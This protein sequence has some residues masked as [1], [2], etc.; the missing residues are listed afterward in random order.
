MK[1]GKCN[2]GRAAVA[3]DE[4]GEMQLRS[5]NDIE[6]FCDMTWKR[7]ATPVTRHRGIE[8][9]RTLNSPSIFCS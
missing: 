3:R 5:G 2:S 7:F 9:T 6:E 1:M 8:A 4:D